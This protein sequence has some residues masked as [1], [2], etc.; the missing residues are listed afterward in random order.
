MTYDL[1]YMQSVLPGKITAHERACQC[2]R[3]IGREVFVF[4]ARRVFARRVGVKWVVWCGVDGSG[5][6]IRNKVCKMI[7]VW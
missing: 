4:D 2:L 3:T 5:L 1:T 6:V 7:H